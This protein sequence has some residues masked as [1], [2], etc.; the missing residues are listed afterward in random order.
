[1]NDTK[2]R[3][4]LDTYSL[5]HGGVLRCCSLRGVEHDP[6]YVLDVLVA[7]N[8]QRRVYI[9]DEV[10]ERIDLLRRDYDGGSAWYTRV[11]FGEARHVPEKAGLWVSPGLVSNGDLRNF[12]LSRRTQEFI[13]PNS[14]FVELVDAC[15]ASLDTSESVGR[16]DHVRCHQLQRKRVWNKSARHGI[17]IRQVRQA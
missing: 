17:G 2:D 4:E 11:V 13:S 12:A 9:D 16:H 5:T 1:M 10:N 8:R 6:S 14:R 7:Q 3:V 15:G